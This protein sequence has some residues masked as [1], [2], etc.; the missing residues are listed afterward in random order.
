MAAAAYAQVVR[1]RQKLDET[2]MADLL[3]CGTEPVGPNETQRLLAGEFNAIWAPPMHRHAPVKTGDRIWL[4]WRSG[5]DPAMLLGVGIVKATEQGKVDWTNR[6]ARGIVSAARAC[7]DRGPTNMA[8]FRLAQVRVPERQTPVSDL[9]SVPIG[10][11]EAS[12]EQIQQLSAA[13][14]AGLPGSAG[15]GAQSATKGEQNAV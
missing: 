12:S 8:F 2:N 14:A 9:G 5:N 3:Y 13:I 4:L 10:L 11:T 7:G 15:S 6:T 1:P